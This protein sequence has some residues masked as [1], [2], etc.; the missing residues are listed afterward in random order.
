MSP[1]KNFQGSEAQ[2]RE[3]LEE[4]KRIV[5]FTTFLHTFTITY[6]KRGLIYQETYTENLREKQYFG[7]YVN[8]KV[9][10][11]VATTFF[12]SLCLYRSH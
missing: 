12:W 3:L 11:K 2:T 9:V 4:Q 6:V 1:Q 10:Q 5:L 7:K 8:V